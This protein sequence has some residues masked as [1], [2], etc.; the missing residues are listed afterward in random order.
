M[1]SSVRD[2][3]EGAAEEVGEV[4]AIFNVS[5]IGSDGLFQ[6][7]SEGAT[8]LDTAEGA[9]ENV[10]ANSHTVN[11]NLNVSLIF[12]MASYRPRIRQRGTLEKAR[13][14]QLRMLLTR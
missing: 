1:G 10:G 4:N 11:P 7:S 5:S 8:V 6:L 12:L 13:L 14:K 9:T 2:T 3:G